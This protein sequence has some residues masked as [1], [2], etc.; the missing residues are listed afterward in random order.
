MNSDF[1][2]RGSPYTRK[3]WGASCYTIVLTACVVVTM[4]TDT[5]IRGL[6]GVIPPVINFRTSQGAA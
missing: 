5:Y 2:K 1:N 3:P 6:D 4:G